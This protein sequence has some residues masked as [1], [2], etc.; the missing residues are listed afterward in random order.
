VRR[1]AIAVFKD[2]AMYLSHDSECF[3][4]REKTAAGESRQ[5]DASG[6]VRAP[7]A[8]SGALTSLFIAEGKQIGQ[9]GLVC[10][11]GEVNSDG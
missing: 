10:E 6:L 3:I 8:D 11:L 9:D 7:V 5:S 4:F 1:R 2:G